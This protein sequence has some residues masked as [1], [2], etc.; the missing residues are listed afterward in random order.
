MGPRSSIDVFLKLHGQRKFAKEVAASGAELEA[1]GLKGAKAMS[2]F[3]AS[4]DKLKKFG[5]SWTH[6]VSLPVAGLGVVSGKMA[7]D[8]DRSMSLIATQAGGSAREVKGLEKAVLGMHN[9][10]T[11]NERAQG[12][13]YIES[14][15]LRGAKAMEMLQANVKL[16]TTGNSN[17]EHTVFGTVGAMNALG[18]EGKNFTKIASIMN[19]TVGHGHMRMEELV[20]AIS[21]GLVGAAKSFGV[22]WAGMNSAVAF[23][24]RMGEPAQQVATRLRQTIT[25]LATNATTKGAKA[26][27]SIGISTE[28]MGQRI[29]KSGRIGPVIK[30]LAE[31]LKMVSKTEADQ[32]LT[33]AFGGGRFGTQIR[34]ATQRWQL[35]LRT[36]KEVAK[37]GTAKQLNRA[38]AIAEKQSAVKLKETWAELSTVLINL[39]NVVLPAAVPALEKLTSVISTAGHAFGGLSPTMQASIAGFLLLTGP[40]ASGLGYF[41]SGVGRALILTTKLAR[42]GKSLQI[43]TS[44]LQA[45]QGLSGSFGMAAEGG[46]MRAALQ[47]AKGFAFSLGPALAAYGIG[48]IVTSALSG[49]WKDAGYEA[50]GAIAGGI[51]GFMIGGPMG[52]MLGVGAGSLGGELVAKLLGSDKGLT[53]LQRQ[54]ASSAKGVSAAFEAQQVAGANLAQASKAVVS[55]K[56]RQKA[57]SQE[58]KNAE[59]ALA[60]AR[61]RYGVDS[62]Q[63]IKDE[64]H[65]AKAGERRKEAVSALQRAERLHGTELSIF[66]EQNAYAILEEKHRINVL[67]RAI[68]PLREQRKAMHE[69]G[70]SIQKMQPL[71]EALSKKEEAL[72]EAHGKLTKSYQ[73]GASKAGS[74]W[75]Q[76]T[77]NASRQALGLGSNIKA[78]RLEVTEMVKAIRELQIESANTESPFESGILQD[79]A[80]KLREGLPQARHHLHSLKDHQGKRHHSGAT[81]RTQS[82]QIPGGAKRELLRRE[83]GT[84]PL[85][86]ALHIHLESQSTL[87]LDGKD[88]AESVT[89]HSTRAA[90]RG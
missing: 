79:R 47:T 46:G 68:R 58:V 67:R 70:A 40:V 20:G 14:A 50:G 87:V 89:R 84:H 83:D 60:T 4:G 12:L 13:F 72:R 36:E 35:L 7:M 16:A 49:D 5:K 77:R 34:E 71:N 53:P 19:S 31:H 78:A 18:K 1:M 33:D 85:G 56:H 10:F 6:N 64:I 55:A 86:E 59:H 37:F 11:P 9:Q 42:A 43:F 15:G 82:L 17:L 8:F 45:G 28:K 75:A 52:A 29:R 63:A 61:Q 90:N 24:T 38:N 44:A 76:F 21:T 62:K 74:A 32:V 54:L 39:G 2:A 57:A 65:L 48:N 80:N 3:A 25:H 51:A 30:E 66:K 22:S 73:E 88:V 41:A 23:F 26:L 81:N 27:E 69:A